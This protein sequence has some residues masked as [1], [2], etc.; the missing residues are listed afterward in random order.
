VLQGSIGTSQPFLFT[1]EPYD[2]ETNLLYLRSRYDDPAI[3]RFLQRDR[4]GG[5]LAAPLSLNRYIYV[6]NNPAS[7]TDPSG[8]TG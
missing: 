3:G 5:L 6:S 2:D 1:G 8:Y 7:L 4:M